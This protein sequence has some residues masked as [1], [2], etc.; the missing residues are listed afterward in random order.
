ML[1]KTNFQ[2]DH[3]IVK[4]PGESRGSASRVV[5]S[6]CS[7]STPE[8]APAPVEPS[9][10]SEP[11]PVLVDWNQ[12]VNTNTEN[13][14]NLAGL[15]QGYANPY[16]NEIAQ[17]RKDNQALKTSHSEQADATLKTQIIHLQTKIEQFVAAE[18]EKAKRQ[19]RESVPRPMMDPSPRVSTDLPS[20]SPLVGGTGGQD[21]PRTTG[22]SNPRST[23]NSGSGRS[24]PSVR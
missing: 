19:E 23:N 13:I 16:G 11:P 1:E 5:F 4:L 21:R 7:Y 8:P 6:L 17:L 12:I 22:T 14:N 15:F 18:K 10:P 9:S 2:M 24:N 3:G 20:P